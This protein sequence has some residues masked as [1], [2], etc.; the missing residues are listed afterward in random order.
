MKSEPSAYAIDDLL[1]DQV[2]HWDGVRN[3]QARNFMR[4]TMR[5]GDGVLFYHSVTHPVGIAGEATVVKTGYPD[6]TAYDPNDIHYDPKSREDRPTWFM[7]NVQ[8]VRK[9]KK[10]IALSALK[11]IPSLEG[12]MLLKRGS[13]LSVQPVMKE[14][15]DI[16][17]RLPEWK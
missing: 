11:E 4:D 2:T 3:Y 17:M 15:W 1:R 7:V 16:I 8:F 9:C 13:R 10:I 6:H 14:E 5:V 12:M